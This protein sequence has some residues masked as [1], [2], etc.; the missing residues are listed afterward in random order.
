MNTAP[1]PR[2]LEARLFVI[3][4]EHLS[5]P[6]RYGH[7][8]LL[9]ASL[10]MGA[11]IASLLSTE[12]GLPERTRWSM[13]V[14]LMIAGAWAAYAT[15]VLGMRRTLLASHRLV[16]AR[17]ATVFTAVFTIGTAAIGVMAEQP[18]FFLA[19]SLGS[20]LFGV[21]LWLLRRARRRIAA[22]EARLRALAA[23]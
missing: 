3:T 15:W 1:S 11:L 19:A 21:S 5:A 10:L 2:D 17:M 23:E 20:A 12:P 9:I 8:A 4:A 7:V 14:M 22:L 6:S 13:A 16:A 18:S